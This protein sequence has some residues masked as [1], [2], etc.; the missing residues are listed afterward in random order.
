MPRCVIV[1]NISYFVVICIL[2]KAREAISA[3]APRAAITCV[4]SRLIDPGIE[5]REIKVILFARACRT[6]SLASRDT[7]R[8]IANIVKLSLERSI[9]IIVSFLGQSSP[10]MDIRNDQFPFLAFASERKAHMTRTK[11]DEGLASRNWRRR[12][13]FLCT[14]VRSDGKPIPREGENEGKRE[15]VIST[16][17]ELV[18]RKRWRF[19]RKSVETVPR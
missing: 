14:V 13:T 5:S 11:C 2:L 10:V 15:S 18:D 1:D 19:C 6:T 4:T 17:L 3:A 8:G 7:D 9:G 16:R 12:S